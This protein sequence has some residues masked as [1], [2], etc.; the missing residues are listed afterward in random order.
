MSTTGIRQRPEALRPAALP[1]PAVIR[2]I[3]VG[4]VMAWALCLGAPAMAQTVELA[5]DDG[6]PVG[7]LTQ[8][9][10]G[11]IEVTRMNPAN[12]A[13]LESVRLFFWTPHCQA[14]LFVWP[15][16]GGNAPDLSHPL[17]TIDTTVDASGW[18]TADVSSLLVDI[19]PPEPFYV[20]HEVDDASPCGVAW[21]M[22]GS[23]EVRSLARLGGNWYSISDG[24]DGV[25]DAMIRATVTYHDLVDPRWFSDVTE[26]IGLPLG[27]RRLAWTDYD[28]DGDPD[29]LVSGR[30]L[31]RNDLGRF[32]E[33]TDQ[34]GIGDVPANG[35][36]WADYD[37]DGFV[38][39]YA[40]VSS[41][42][43]DCNGDDDCV[44]CSLTTN[45]QGVSVCDEYFHDWTCI[46]GRCTPPSGAQA[47]DVL[48]HNNGDGTFTDMSEEAG[49]P[50]DFFP[51]EAAAWGDYD[52][53]GFVDLYVA[54]Y[55]VPPTWVG[56]ARGVGTPDSLWHNNGDGTFTDVS[57]AAG[58]RSYPEDQCGRGVT[59]ADFDQDGDLDIYVANYR[60]DFNFLW[61]NQGDGTFWNVASQ[62]GTAGVLIQGAF[63]HSI[64]ADWADFDN[65]GDWDLFVANL[66]HPRFIE[67]SDKSMLYQSDG[68]P[69][70]H[71]TDIRQQAGITYSETHSDPAWGDFDNDGWQDL[72]VTDVYEGYFA[73]LYRN[74]TD[75]TFRD[76]TYPSGILFDNGWGCTWADFDGDGRLD[77]VSQRA[78]H[79][80][81]PDTGHFLAVHLTGN[82]SNR[83][84]IGAQV[85]VTSGGLT[86]MRQVSG[87]RGTG[88]QN[89]LTLHFGLGPA[90]EV[91]RLV[92]T[93]PSGAVDVYSAIQVDQRLDLIEGAGKADASVDEELDG[94]LDSG[95]ETD[96]ATDEADS[97]CSCRSAD[98]SIPSWPWL[99][100]GWL[101]WTITRKRGKIVAMKTSPSTEP[102]PASLSNQ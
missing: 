26:N 83:A 15:D 5:Y 95:R 19:D 17:A 65:D 88:N 21:S 66:A 98:A 4:L 79:N 49:R 11:D 48:W 73:F 77:L 96:G 93:W 78:W 50:Y 102:Q 39:F 86:M 29:L 82:P 33:V 30:R 3:L 1:R 37:N 90:D 14:H 63:G 89:P 8:L 99:L 51:S 12:P 2:S 52:N 41:F 40:T 27:M 20:G 62:T 31:F 72:F 47:H 76:V 45:T 68:S 38:D 71:F 23:T 25:L 101:L 94:G 36:V 85:T 97:G 57:E 10:G 75:G 69:D 60:L 67:F 61:K 81:S 59:W 42:H 22:Q 87:G 43:K 92:V 53:D 7:S 56:G 9:A 34:A 84:A 18:L 54:N 58:I 91:D 16:N 35:G 80:D 32:T 6:T 55:E 28:N 46:G 74:Q 100:V 44:Y 64:G 70:F 24:Q 13:R